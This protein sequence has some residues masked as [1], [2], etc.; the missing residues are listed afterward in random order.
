MMTTISSS[1]EMM[2][3]MMMWKRRLYCRI[4]LSTSN[5]EETFERVFEKEEASFL[6]L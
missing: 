4:L 6:L 1:R 3:M 2:M 5:G